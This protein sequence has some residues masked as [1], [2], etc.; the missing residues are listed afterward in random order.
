MTP[1]A[2]LGRKLPWSDEAGGIIKE[3]TRMPSPLCTAVG[4]VIR[5]MGTE[6]VACHCD[7]QDRTYRFDVQYRF[8][9]TAFVRD[10]A[11]RRGL[12]HARSLDPGLDQQQLDDMLHYFE[13]SSRDVAYV[14]DVKDVAFMEEF[15]NLT[16]WTW[17][18]VGQVVHMATVRHF[19]TFWT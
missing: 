16:A 11:C 7:C 15:P 18:E 1:L 17:E 12:L 2:R 5:E 3:F 14:A 4:E 13:V 9:G 8:D 6:D 19:A 10:V